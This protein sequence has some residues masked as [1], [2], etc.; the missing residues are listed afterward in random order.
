MK[1][2]TLIIL[3]PD[4]VNRTIIGELI[5]IFER[6][7]LKIIGMKMIHLTPEQ[8]KEHYSHHVEK[9]FYPRLENFMRT[10]PT[11][12]LVLEGK[13]SVEIVRKLAGQTHGKE[14]APGTIRGD[15]AMGMQN[16]VHASDS[17]ENAKEEIARFFKLEEIFDYERVDLNMI[18][19]EEERV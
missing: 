6:K 10:C 12:L 13:N 4:A 15:Y 16:V 14:A 18:Y 19:S 11:V 5:H 7:G 3:K 1:E 2:R 9:P 8:L 17:V